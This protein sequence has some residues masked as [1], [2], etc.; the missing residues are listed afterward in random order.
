MDTEN[1]NLAKIGKDL[2]SQWNEQGVGKVLQQIADLQFVLN[3]DDFSSIADVGVHTLASC[4][5][6]VFP[7]LPAREGVPQKTC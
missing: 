1:C 4:E 3:L 7:F 2:G 6:K 5:A